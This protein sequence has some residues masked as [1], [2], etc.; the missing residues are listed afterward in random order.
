MMMSL[1]V[2]LQS[3][4]TEGGFTVISQ[5]LVLQSDVTEGGF[6]V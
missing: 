5:M 2:V 1:M 6:T 4:V 3:D